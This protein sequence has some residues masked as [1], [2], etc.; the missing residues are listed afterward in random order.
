[1]T[2]TTVAEFAKE[3]KKSPDTLLEQLKSAGVAKF[4]NVERDIAVIVKD[5]VTHAEVMAAVHAANTQ[6]LLRQ[7]VLFDV[8]RPA[9]TA[10]KSFAVRLSLQSED[11]TL[12]DEQIDSVVQAVIKHLAERTGAR[13][14]A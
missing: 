3:L 8:Y 12:T 6:G 14:R 1:M 13:L 2:I 11:A 9:N 10:E 5:R 4:P 7:A